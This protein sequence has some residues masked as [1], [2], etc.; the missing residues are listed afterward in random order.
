MKFGEECYMP[1]TFFT[2]KLLSFGGIGC[3]F[4]STSKHFKIKARFLI[5]L[6]KLDI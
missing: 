1:I 4:D 6:F 3:D 5:N 2:I